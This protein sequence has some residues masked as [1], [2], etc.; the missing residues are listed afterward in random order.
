MTGIERLLRRDLHDQ[1]GPG[2]VEIAPMRRRDLKRGVLDVEAACH[3]LPWSQKV[4]TSE[5]DQM[6][7]G[8]RYYVTAQIEQRFVGHAGLWFAPD[9]AHITNV[10]VSPDHRRRGIARQMLIAL[11]DVAVERGHDAWTLEVRASSTGAHELYRQFG[12]VP[13]GIRQ[14]YYAN[15]EDAIVMWCHDIRTP[16][17]AERLDLLRTDRGDST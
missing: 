15:V 3:P 2:N 7:Q 9:E 11:A 12:F 1:G 5:V 8:S 4:F 14:K 13:A 17:Y 16:Q 10:A 6:R